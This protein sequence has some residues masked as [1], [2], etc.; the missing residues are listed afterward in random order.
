MQPLRTFKVSF[1]AT[2]ILLLMVS[3]NKNPGPYIPDF[4][5]IRGSVIGRETC[6]G[7]DADDYLLIDL[8][9]NPGV[10]HYRDTL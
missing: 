6:K 4:Q 1:F 8:A 3:C 9:A 10:S 5:I 2:V 7:V